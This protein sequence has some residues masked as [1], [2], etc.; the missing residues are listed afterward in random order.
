MDLVRY[1]LRENTHD[2][3]NL[4]QSWK[5]GEFF[6]IVI[7]IIYYYSFF[8][9]YLVATCFSFAKKIYVNFVGNTQIQTM[10][11]IIIYI[12]LGIIKFQN[13]LES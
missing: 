11:N 10:P 12:I 8:F 6:I 4:K 2:C 3:L 13:F 9:C 1:I 7:I 5:F